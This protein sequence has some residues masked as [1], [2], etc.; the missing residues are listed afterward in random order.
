MTKN[1]SRRALF[2]GAVST[3]WLGLM[4]GIQTA[5]AEPTSEE[6]QSQL[7]EARQRLE[8]VGNTLS[9]LQDELMNAQVDL[10]NIRY[11]VEQTT[12]QISDT[13]TQLDEKRQEL[14]ARMKSSYKSGSSSA[15][16]LILSSASFEEL[17]SNIYYLDKVS[18]ADAEAISEVQDLANQLAEQQSQLQAQQ[19]EQEAKIEATQQSVDDYTAQVSEAQ[20]YYN[21]LDTAVQEQ[22]AKEAEEAQQQ[23]AAASGVAAAVATAESANGAVSTSAADTSSQSSDNG[24]SSGSSSS[25]SSSGGSSN[26]SSNSSSS[27]G[28]SSSSSGSSSSGSS[29]SSSGGGSKTY[30]SSVIANAAQ[31]IGYPYKRWTQGVNYG[32]NADGFDCCGLVATAYHMAGYSTPSYATSVPGLIAEMKSRGNW[33]DCNLSNYQ[34]VLSPGDV[35]FCSTGHV[36]IY[37]G[38][39]TMIHA[40]V[41]GSYVC[42]ANVYACIGGGFGG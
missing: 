2:L 25:S 39:S 11:Q 33:K 9:S 31:F 17:S 6:L 37:C 27:S 42:Y 12:Q 7:E 10:E 19:D 5:Q 14:G 21:S 18:E 40:P 23:N 13:Q 8:S 38:G 30:S 28:D 35:I 41:P 34:S 20:D 3:T 32:P 15:L 1:I 24:S 26:S 16:D 22:L 36:A 29:S 4:S